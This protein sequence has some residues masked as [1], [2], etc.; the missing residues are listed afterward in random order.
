MLVSANETKR[1]YFDGLLMALVSLF[2]YSIYRKLVNTFNGLRITEQTELV[3]GDF[4]G[5]EKNI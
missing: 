3:R 2:F 4:Y 1:G 5:E